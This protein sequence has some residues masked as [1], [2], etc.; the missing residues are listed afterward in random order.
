MPNV[1]DLTWLPKRRIEKVYPSGC[2]AN[3]TSEV[4]TLQ[5]Y[6]SRQWNDV[7][8]RPKPEPE[9]LKW[10]PTGQAKQS[11]SRWV[12]GEGVFVEYADCPHG[13]THGQMQ[14]RYYTQAP[15]PFVLYG[16][17]Q[18]DSD[19]WSLKMR[20]KVEDQLI[21]LGT[22]LAEYRAS[23]DQFGSYVK[24][25]R[26][27]YQFLRGKRK[28]KRIH[29]CAI[30]AA[31]LQYSF[32]IAPLASDLYDSI[33]ALR[34]SLKRPIE[35]RLFVSGKRFYSGE[36]VFGPT[37]HKWRRKLSQHATSWIELDPEATSP[38]SF[39][40]PIEWAWE[41]QPFSWLVDYVIPVGEWLGSLDSLLLSGINR[42]TTTVTTKDRYSATIYY[43]Q[44]GYSNLNV[45]YAK[46]QS[47]EREVVAGL[48]IPPLP[49]W[50]PSESWHKVRN[51]AAVLW[52]MNKRCSGR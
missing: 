2:L 33:E 25:L 28:R 42:M 52:T 51:A 16:D 40:N 30:P 13:G 44:D 34:F 5:Q 3:E 15:T 11:F 46:H 38:F 19:I 21:N 7:D 17:D 48:P 47:H 50:E 43:D 14:T 6:T 24:A 18:L 29:P 31:A 27:G 10:F 37:R 26:N 49:S 8:R 22:T 20:V 45:G 9:E 12:G 32:G 36:E 35:R 23:V 4:S 1:T 41:R 39:G